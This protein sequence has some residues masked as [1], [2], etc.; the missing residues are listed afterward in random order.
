[1]LEAV[2]LLLMAETPRYGY[3]LWGLLGEE[4]LLAG[5]VYP[6]RIYETLRRLAENGFVA[7]STEE[8]TKGPARA[9]YAI[10]AAGSERLERWRIGLQRSYD[11]VGQF[12]MRSEQLGLRGPRAAPTGDDRRVPLASGPSKG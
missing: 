11:R 12:L 7:A 8:S 5:R 10:T 9:R 4:E 3:E 1:M 2:L 6:G